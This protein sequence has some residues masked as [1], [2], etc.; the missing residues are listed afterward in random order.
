MLHIQVIMPNLSINLLRQNYLLIF[1][2][3]KILAIIL[4]GPEL[5]L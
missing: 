1:F 2:K 5:A 4:S 3:A